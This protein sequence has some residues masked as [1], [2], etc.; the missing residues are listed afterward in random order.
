MPTEC[1]NCGLSLDAND[2]F[3]GNCGQAADTG[4]AAHGGA[5]AAA[6]SPRGSDRSGAG[7]PPASE[8]QPAQQDQA[9]TAGAAELA[10]DLERRL[11]AD[12][13]QMN[14]ELTGDW[15]FDPLRN[16]RFL[17]Q[18]ARRLGLY[19]AAALAVQIIFFLF[20]AVTDLSTGNSPSLGGGAKVSA[21][22]WIALVLIFWLVPVPGL[23][24]Q[25]SNLLS[26]QAPAA[27]RAFDC[28]HQAIDRHAT[29]RDALRER[30]YPLPGEG[31][32][33][34]LEL[35]R[36]VFTGYISCFPHGNDLYVGYSFWIRMSPLRLLLMRIGRNIQD[37]T[38]RGN[39]MYQTLRYES[40]RATVGAIHICTVEGIKAAIGESGPAGPQAGQPPVSPVPVPSPAGD[41]ARQRVRRPA[42]QGGWPGSG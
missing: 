34:F 4:S 24:R 16:R 33:R 15:S 27:Q 13:A 21:L 7:V 30:G 10:A 37:W 11:T 23:L 42:S 32:R 20:T 12:Q 26:D 39:D 9:A 3:C 5:I 41:Q 17:W 22:L 40:T 8:M 25:W 6:A 35:H 19:T 2:A 29:P 1:R 14:F 36:G 38:G 28:I 31:H 18:I